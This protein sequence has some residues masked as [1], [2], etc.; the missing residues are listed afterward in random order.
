MARTLP[1]RTVDSMVAI[2]VVRL[3][4]YAI[5]WSPTNT[6]SQIDHVIRSGLAVSFLECKGVEDGVSIPIDLEQL[7]EYAHGGGPPDTLY[8]LPSAPI[9][10]KAPYERVCARSCCGH[11]CRF[12]PRDARAWGGLERWIN[13][14][15]LE[16]R[17]QPWFAHWAWCVPCQ[18][19]AAHLGLAAGTR[20]TGRAKL[21]WDDADLG[22]LPDAIRLCHL[23]APHVGPSL[24][25]HRAR[26]LEQR[27]AAALLELAEIADAEASPPLLVVHPSEAPR[28]Q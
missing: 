26:P 16:Q 23:F 24:A 2:E 12:C 6:R 20:P 21:A 28:P 15:G 14:L 13:E 8:V 27:D 9:R 1:E 7:W 4:P 17:L 25:A 19:L 10:S 3:Q 18:P 5:V 22:A 11:W